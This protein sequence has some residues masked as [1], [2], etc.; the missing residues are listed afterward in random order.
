MM[1]VEDRSACCGWGVAATWGCGWEGIVP[2]VD[3]AAREASARATFGSSPTR[4]PHA[5]Q[6]LQPG[7]MGA[8]QLVQKSVP[9]A[10]VVPAASALS[11]LPADSSAGPASAEG[12]FSLR[13]A[14]Q[15][16]Q[17]LLP[18]GNWAPHFVQN[19]R[20]SLS[21]TCLAELRRHGISFPCMPNI[22]CSRGVDLLRNIPVG[23]RGIMYL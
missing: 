20:L 5:V 12:A 10:L 23:G 22:L 7:S 2:V 13:G 9:A 17:N 15:A 6:K 18:S 19:M 4:W 8:P 11:A 1:G 16:V 21:S 3:A 14:P